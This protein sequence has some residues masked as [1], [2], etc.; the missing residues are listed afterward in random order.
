MTFRGA[1]AEFLPIHISNCVFKECLF[2]LY[3]RQTETN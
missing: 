3:L 1:S 2:E